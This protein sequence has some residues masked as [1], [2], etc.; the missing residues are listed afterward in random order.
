MKIGI[1]EILIGGVLLYLLTQKKSNVYSGGV[2][3]TL[4]SNNRKPEMPYVTQSLYNY[5]T[6]G[7]LGFVAPRPDVATYTQRVAGITSEQLPARF[8]NMERGWQTNFEVVPFNGY[9]LTRFNPI[10]RVINFTV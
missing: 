1:N 6:A 4:P 3:Q 2:T 5:G 10:T 9:D 7:L 8:K